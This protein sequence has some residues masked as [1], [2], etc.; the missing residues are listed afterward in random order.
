[1]DDNSGFTAHENLKELNKI[2]NTELDKVGSWYTANELAI[3]ESRINIIFTRS[4][5]KDET[6]NHFFIKLNL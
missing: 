4:I 6:I 2:T 5:N 1:M 3:Y